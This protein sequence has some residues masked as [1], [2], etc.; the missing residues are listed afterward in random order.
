MDLVDL[1][2]E[3][4][5]EPARPMLHKP[6]VDTRYPYRILAELAEHAEENRRTEHRGR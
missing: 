6:Q 1:R 5:Q 2:F 3:Q 4:G